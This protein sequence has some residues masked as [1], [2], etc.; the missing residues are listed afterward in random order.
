M[1]EQSN[2]EQKTWQIVWDSTYVNKA[3]QA[4]K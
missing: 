3:Q 1:A 4:E 2:D